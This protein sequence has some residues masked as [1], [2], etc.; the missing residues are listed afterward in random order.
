MMGQEMTQEINFLAFF[1]NKN[2]FLPVCL[3]KTVIKLPASL[4]IWAPRSRFRFYLIFYLRNQVRTMMR[5]HDL[6]PVI[7]SLFES[8]AQTLIKKCSQLAD[9]YKA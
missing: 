9:L 1:F 8:A 4:R 2:I 7:I 6:S 5:W 3:T